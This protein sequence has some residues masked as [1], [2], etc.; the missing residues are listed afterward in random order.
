[1]SKIYAHLCDNRGDENITKMIWIAISFVVGAILLALI[2][3]AFK[4]PVSSWYEGVIK[5]WFNS[6]ESGLNGAYQSS[7]PVNPFVTEAA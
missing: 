5:S 2:V 7:E 4:G 3:G 6:D 1:M